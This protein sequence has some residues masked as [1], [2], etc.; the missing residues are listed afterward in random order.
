MNATACSWRS[1]ART[2]T[3]KR[4]RNEDVLDLPQAGLWAVADGMGGH[5]NGALA[6]RLI[7]EQLAE[8]SGAAIWPS[9]CGRCGAVCMSSIAGSAR[10]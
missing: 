5:Q 4:A 3:G 9:G 10:N 7:I 6:S 1:A 8:L 2:D